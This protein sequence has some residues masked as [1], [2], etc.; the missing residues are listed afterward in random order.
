MTTRLLIDSNQRAESIS[1]DDDMRFDLG[2]SD[3]TRKVFED[4][5]V[6]SLWAQKAPKD[7]LSDR[8]IVSSSSKAETSIFGFVGFW[9]VFF[10][11]FLGNLIFSVKGLEASK[12]QV[13]Q[14]PEEKSFE[15]AGKFKPDEFHQMMKKNSDGNF[16]AFSSYGEGLLD[17]PYEISGVNRKEGESVSDAIIRHFEELALVP[18]GLVQS[19]DSDEKFSQKRARHLCGFLKLLGDKNNSGNVL[20]TDV[21]TQLLKP[22]KLTIFC[23]MKDIGQSTIGFEV[24]D[25]EVGL[26]HPQVRDGEPIS[27]YKTSRIVTV[28]PPSDAG[29]VSYRIERTFTRI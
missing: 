26:I 16:G 25:E 17:Y 19:L 29:Y 23:P 24:Q 11:T 21:D 20:S 12:A 18:D 15:E 9:V 8:R 13:K 10:L 27:C 14:V 22:G 1:E 7:D 28:L 6:D 4:K 2:R 5:V 3:T